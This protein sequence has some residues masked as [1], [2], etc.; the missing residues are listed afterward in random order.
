MLSLTLLAQ[1][2]ELGQLNRR[3]IAKLVGVAPFNQDSG[4]WRGSRHIWGGRA[5]VRAPLFM[6]TLSAIRFNPAIKSFYRRLLSAGKAPKVAIVACMRKLLT[7]LN[8][9]VK[10]QTSWRIVQ[11]P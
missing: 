5:T 2:P 10:T 11:S 7:I 8:V 3:A 4:Q 6:A 9:M 1:L